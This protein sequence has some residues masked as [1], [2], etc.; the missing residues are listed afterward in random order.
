MSGR[1]LH[2]TR[3]SARA[4]A[5]SPTLPHRAATISGLLRPGLPRMPP[6]Q[7]AMQVQTAPLAL[8]QSRLCRAAS[9]APLSCSFCTVLERSLTLHPC[10][11]AALNTALLEV[12]K[13]GTRIHK[14]E[15]EVAWYR[16][17]ADTYWQQLQHMSA[18]AAALNQ[19]H[20]LALSNQNQQMAALAQYQMHV[21][22]AAQLVKSSGAP[23]PGLQVKRLL[24]QPSCRHCA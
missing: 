8:L 19:Q 11:L 9:Q 16:T 21:N 1:T 24:L 22:A 7:T 15:A 14:L 18:A 17:W 4:W 2:P 23:L 10:L 20:M 13:R 3:S 5:H 12:E 6:L